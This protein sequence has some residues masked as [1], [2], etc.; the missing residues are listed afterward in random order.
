MEDKAFGAGSEF[1]KLGVIILLLLEVAILGGRVVINE[2][3]YDPQGA[4]GGKEW[5]ELYNSGNESIDLSSCRIY[6]RGTVWNL[7]FEFPYYVLRPG[8]F[9]LVGGEAVANAQFV[10]DLSF[11]NGGNASDAVRFVNA[12]STYTDTVIYDEPNTSEITDDFGFLAESFAPDVREGNSLARV[13]DGFDTNYSAVDFLE[14]QNPSP[15]APNHVYTDYALYDPVL[16]KLGPG[17]ILSVGVR[18]LGP[19]S[20][21]YYAEFMAYAGNSL[22][23]QQTVSPLTAGD[24]LRLEFVV[25]DAFGLVIMTLQ[26][27]NDTDAANNILHFSELGAVSGAVRFS[28]VFPAPLPGRQEWLEIEVFAQDSR[29]QYQI[30]DAGGGLIS[31]TLPPVP[32]YF[33]V[34]AD[35]AELL[36]DYPELNPAW[37][38]QSQ[39]WTALN[40]NGDTL[41]LW[42]DGALIDSLSYISAPSAMSYARYEAEGISLWKWAD[43]SPTLANSSLALEIPEHKAPLKLLGSPCDARKGELISISY[44]MPHPVSRVN[45]RVYDLQGRLVATLADNLQVPQTGILTWNGRDKGGAYARRGIYF[46]LWESQADGGGKIYRRQLT[47]VLR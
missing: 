29:G 19:Y 8:R 21:P 17:D 41:H 3:C 25:P 40:N 31:F 20:S 32:G 14:E 34:C 36:S 18:N 11:Q 7:A 2:L 30:S 37:L 44:K 42:E 22:I 27:A 12:D 47:A 13:V 45:C 15:G 38:I 23:H 24:S 39:G 10:A 26:L 6:S 16:Y 46:L 43:P 9:V 33:V 5:I 1:L 35:P 28:E 4:D